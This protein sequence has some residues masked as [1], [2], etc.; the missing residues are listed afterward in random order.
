MKAYCEGVQ[1]EEVSYFG[2]QNALDL[3]RA[4]LSAIFREIR[5]ITER[6]VSELPLDL[7]DKL[8]D[9]F[10]FWLSGKLPD[11]LKY[12]TFDQKDLLR[13]WIAV[14]WETI[15][16]KADLLLNVC[17]DFEPLLQAQVMLL[18]MSALRCRSECGTPPGR[19]GHHIYDR[20]EESVLLWLE[21][22]YLSP[23]DPLWRVAAVMLTKA[24]G[25]PEKPL[26]AVAET[27]LSQVVNGQV[28]VME[29]D[30]LL[31]L[32]ILIVLKSYPCWEW[33]L[34]LQLAKQIISH[35]VHEGFDSFTKQILL[36][37]GF[38]IL[39]RLSFQGYLGEA[40]APSL[41]ATGPE[42]L[43]NFTFG[44]SSLI[45]GFL[46]E[47]WFS[48]LFLPGTQSDL[49]TNLFQLD[50]LSGLYS[51]LL[52]FTENISK[53]TC[54][55]RKSRGVQLALEKISIEVR[56]FSF[57]V[58]STLFSRQGGVETPTLVARTIYSMKMI[59][60]ILEHTTATSQKASKSSFR[61]SIVAFLNDESIPPYLKKDLLIYF[62]KNYTT[63][64]ELKEVNFPNIF[65]QQQSFFTKGLLF[66]L[67]LD[68]TSGLV[69]NQDML[70]T[71]LYIYDNLFEC[72][73]GVCEALS[74]L[75]EKKI[76][77][78]QGAAYAKGISKQCEGILRDLLKLTISEEE[79]KVPLVDKVV[80]RVATQVKGLL[81]NLEY[82]SYIGAREHNLAR[83]TLAML[84]LAHPQRLPLHAAFAQG[85]FMQLHFQTLTRLGDYYSYRHH[86]LPDA[87]S[88]YRKGELMDSKASFENGQVQFLE[89]SNA[90]GFGDLFR[91]DLMGVFHSCLGLVS[92]RIVIEN[93]SKVFLEELRVIVEAEGMMQQPPQNLYILDQFAASSTRTLKLCFSVKEFCTMALRI[94]LTTKSLPNLSSDNPQIAVLKLDSLAA[95][96][97][98][99]MKKDLGGVWD[100]KIS[101]FLLASPLHFS[102]LPVH[103][104][105]TYEEK[106]IFS[107]PLV[108][109]ELNPPLQT[110]AQFFSNPVLSNVL[111]FIDTKPKPI[112]VKEHIPEQYAKL[113]QILL[114][115]DKPLSFYLLFP[116]VTVD[117]HPV[118]FQLRVDKQGTN[119]LYRFCIRSSKSKVVDIF[120]HSLAIKECE[121]LFGFS[122]KTPTTPAL[123]GTSSGGVGGSLGNSSVFVAAGTPPKVV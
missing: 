119:T 11:E 78:D 122:V 2:S 116:R 35:C 29:N 6:K 85:L 72:I 109:I 25:D 49:T 103:T 80:E 82:N 16:D 65:K 19:L 42:Q 79:T 92:I 40:L 10:D 95:T 17:K 1:H 107:S 52:L 84:S 81:L 77:I 55:D 108:E 43:P 12:L 104:I 83:E 105:K 117:T 91:V 69:I 51:S 102:D 13:P 61:P 3:F 62:L 21:K 120:V 64:D 14:M 47:G 96:R 89:I 32:S 75:R 33:T 8:S 24:V 71:G 46:H 97:D 123:L 23:L 58:L 86:L 94:R 101:P 98:L 34:E 59:A 114:E 26:K 99:F 90:G 38:Y 37:N 106:L 50:L 53:E 56:D 73:Y 76:L 74:H 118:A 27:L 39:L 36:L 67:S 31:N 68:R 112:V 70:V 41:L 18:L 30:I 87:A 115:E 28:T 57:K 111:L 48:N 88:I 5:E 44:R 15:I 9:I 4:L 110:L 100:L 63:V 66:N 20:I 60:Y 22:D 45:Y 113:R 121:K 54:L 93:H 7:L